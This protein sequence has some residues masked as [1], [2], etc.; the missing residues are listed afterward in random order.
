MEY[1]ACRLA[2]G[3]GVENSELMFL[4][5]CE[6]TKIVGIRLSGLGTKNKVIRVQSES[7]KP[8]GA[9]VEL[10][11]LERKGTMHMQN[12]TFNGNSCQ[13]PEVVRD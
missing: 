1:Q 12:F 10:I 5:H 7:L 13:V 11:H 2:L 8:W 6:R 4:R 3:G 9:F